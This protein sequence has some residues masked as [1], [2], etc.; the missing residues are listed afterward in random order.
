MPVRT[1]LLLFLLSLFPGVVAHADRALFAG[2]CF[3]CMEQAFQELP[4]VTSV[5]SG[6]TGGRLENPTYEGNHEGHLEAVEVVFDAQRIDYRQLLSV[7]WR[8]IDPFDDGGQ[9]CDRGPSY[10]SAIFV[11]DAS[12]R[13]LAEASRHEVEARFPDRQVVTPVR[14]AGPF[15]PVKAYHQDYYLKN[16]I[17]YR[18]YKAS[19]GRSARLHEVWGR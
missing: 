6:F 2:G 16:P 3:W 9:F 11:L 5:V 18:F 4:G 10:R 1:L 19:C 12:Q 17:R 13:R 15:Y 7:F 14:D 8:N